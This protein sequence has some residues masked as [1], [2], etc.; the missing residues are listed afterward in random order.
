MMIV[1]DAMMMPLDDPRDWQ[2]Q[3]EADGFEV[4]KRHV[5]IKRHAMCLARIIK[6]QVWID[7]PRT[8]AVVK[9]R[10]TNP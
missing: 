7:T 8:W 1:T 6:A 3:A 9:T 5:R 4:V 2:P 10:A